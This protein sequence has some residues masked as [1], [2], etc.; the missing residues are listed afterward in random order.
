MHLL[1]FANDSPAKLV[2][3]F[4]LTTW[5]SDLNFRAID[6]MA[7]ILLIVI[8]DLLLLLFV[9]FFFVLFLFLFF[10]F[11]FFVFTFFMN[12]LYSNKMYKE[13]EQPCIS[14]AFICLLLEKKKHT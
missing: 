4:D 6:C 14:S 8:V 12:T 3:A 11:C 1:N 7:S 9:W 5:P 10:V 13:Y 2:R